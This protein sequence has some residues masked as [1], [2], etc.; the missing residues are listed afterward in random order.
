MKESQQIAS[1]VLIL[2][3]HLF[4]T[5]LCIRTSVESLRQNFLASGVEAA[6]GRESSGASLVRVLGLS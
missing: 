1:M 5:V 3:M 2:D 4:Y 6:T